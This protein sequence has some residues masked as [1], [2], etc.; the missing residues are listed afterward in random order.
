VSTTQVAGAYGEGSRKNAPGF[1][2]EM[3]SSSGPVG[4]ILEDL[5]EADRSSLL[6]ELLDA[7]IYDIP[8]PPARH[9]PRAGGWS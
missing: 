5:H 1:V 6:L 8:V 2:A 7:R 3:A 4:L 9:L